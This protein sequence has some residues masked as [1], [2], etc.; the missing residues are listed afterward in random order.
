MLVFVDFSN[1][2]LDRFLTALRRAKVPPIPLKA[3][4]TPTNARWTS[5][6]LR[7]ELSLEFRARS[8]APAP[9]DGE[10]PSAP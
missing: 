8:G 5:G 3:V 7:E 9:G 4:L 6:K 10:G 1:G 2:L